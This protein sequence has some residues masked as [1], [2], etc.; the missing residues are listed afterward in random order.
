MKRDMLEEHDRR[1]NGVLRKVYDQHGWTPI[2]DHTP[3]DELMAAEVE[4]DMDGEAPEGAYAWPNETQP[5]LELASLKREEAAQVAALAREQL[6]RWIAGAGLHPFRLVQRFYA[7]CYA[8][9]GDLIG[10]LNG[11]CLAEIMGQGRAAF[12]ATMREIFGKPIERKLGVSL[13]V[14]GQ[15]TAAAKE[16]YAEN[17]AKH[18]PRQQLDRDEVND[19]LP[20]GMTAEEA[21]R[22]R[23]EA[24][25]AWEARQLERDA[26]A[27]EEFTRRVKAQNDSAHP[28][29]P[30]DPSHD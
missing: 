23:G 8:R 11:D 2:E 15:K 6:V 4:F 13:K 25:A 27:H 16:K 1:I 20:P 14:P 24:R 22:R 30:H 29:K 7:L 21:A 28:S 18:K 17:A 10:P 12:S 3:L 5:D 9:Y 19:D 26:A